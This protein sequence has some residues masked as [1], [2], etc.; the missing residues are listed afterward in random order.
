[1]LK[2][3]NKLEQE[4]KKLQEK[5]PK[6]GRF[7]G[8]K[9]QMLAPS[10]SCAVQSSIVHCRHNGNIFAT[11]SQSANLV[12]GPTVGIDARIVGTVRCAKMW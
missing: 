2:P 8:N 11:I 9:K 4:S 6:N 10:S 5:Y 3:F 12:R 7:S 1:M